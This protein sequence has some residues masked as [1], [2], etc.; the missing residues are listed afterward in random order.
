[1]T[2]NQAQIEALI[3]R[4]AGINAEL[5]AMQANDRCST[6][7]YTEDAYFSRA[8]ELYSIHDDIQA[9]ARSGL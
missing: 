6:T 9:I 1:M 3:I 5:L 4:A 2:F 7:P 8:Q